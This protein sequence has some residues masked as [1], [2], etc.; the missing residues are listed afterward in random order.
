MTGEIN[1]MRV[2]YEEEYVELN[3]IQEYVL[4]YKSKKEDPVVVFLHGGPGSSIS[5]FAYEMEK[6]HIGNYTMVY[7]DQRGAGKTY[8]KNKLAI[9]TIELLKED[10][11]ATVIYLKKCYQKEKLVLLGHSFGS[12]LGTLMAK[13][14]PEHILCYIGVGQV[15]DMIENEKVGYEKLVEAIDDA[16]DE[17]SKQILKEIGVYPP[18][19]YEVTIMKKINKVRKLQSQ[20]KLA[21]GID[22]KIIFLALKSPIFKFSDLIA[23]SKIVKVN[24]QALKNLWEYSLYQFDAM[25]SIPVFYILGEM[26]NQTPIEISCSY[27]ETI[28]APEKH[29]FI[30]KNAGHLTMLDNPEDFYQ[31]L[32]TV[33]DTIRD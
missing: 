14:H 22:K 15:I 21:M 32:N 18:I 9:P 8:T 27:F 25:Y 6:Y 26:D 16:N 29:M 7:Y 33:I 31:A 12:V 1:S 13:E 19:D 28:E 10:L 4:H 11:L 24:A 20:Y 3:G 2:N 5:L 23:F 30:I 17:K